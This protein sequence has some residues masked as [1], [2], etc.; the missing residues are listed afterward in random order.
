MVHFLC[1]LRGFFGVKKRKRKRNLEFVLKVFLL[2]DLVGFGATD[3]SGAKF[4]D[5]FLFWVKF[6]FWGKAYVRVSMLSLGV[7]FGSS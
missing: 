4:L 1:I 7:A 2:L 6:E 5:F 3:S